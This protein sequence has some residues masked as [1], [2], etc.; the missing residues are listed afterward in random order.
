MENNRNKP[1]SVFI[2]SLIVTI[3]VAAWGILSPQSMGNSASTAFNWLTLNFSW[4]Y[5]A[6]MFAFIV[7]VLALAF[8]KY[9]VVRLGPDDSKP[10]HTTLSWFAMLFSAGMGVGLVFWG[11]AEPLTHFL[12]PNPIYGLTPGSPEAGEFALFASFMHWGLHPWAAYAVVALPMAYMQFR[13]NKP[14]LVS[15]ALIPLIGDEGAKGPIG[16]LVDILAIFATVAGI[17]T[18]LGLG[19]MQINSG[20]NYLFDVPQND[21]TI[22]I[23]IIVATVLYVGTALIGIDKGISLIADINIYIAGGIMAVLFVLGPTRNILEMLV[24]TIG[25]YIYRIIPDSMALSAWGDNS[26]IYGWRVFYWAWWIAW[27]PFSGAFI[28][29]ISKGRTIREFVAGVTVVPALGSF[30]WFAIFGTIGINQ[31]AE[32]A[33]KATEVTESAIFHVLETVPFGNVLSV[34]IIILVFTFFVTS[35]NSG[36]YA[37]GMM[38]EG[39][40]LNPSKKALGLWG[41]LMAVVAYGL[42][43]A[44]GLEVLQ[45][46]SIVAAF[47]FAFVMIFLMIAFVKA[48]KEEDI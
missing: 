44:G 17:G 8:S 4:F 12:G 39:G 45:T 18:S 13:K 21:F 42:M 32:F 10:E 38:S 30:I 46:A 1:S 47:P 9:G 41:V 5:L 33:A 19:A 22:L 16:K 2:I 35:A 27:A 48:L 14:A 6:I 26:W 11:A 25:Q 15:S 28:A 23:I 43:L 34:V 37:L 7:F 20:L 36:T 29:R 24:S 40:T 31:G 3:L